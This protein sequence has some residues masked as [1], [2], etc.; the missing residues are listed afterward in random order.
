ML[1]VTNNLMKLNLENETILIIDDY[2]AMRKSIKSMLYSL[3]AKHIFEAYNGITAIATL[4]QQKIDIVL[5]DYNLGEGKNGQQILDE[6]KYE[7]LLPIS[8]L[9]II[10]TAELAA[11]SVLNTLENKP[12]DYLAKPF[13]P[14]QLLIRLEKSHSR[15][16][17]LSAIEK[18]IDQGNL[19][20]AIYYCDALLNQNNKPLRSLLLKIR[21]DLAINAGDF[22]KASS[23]YQETLEQRELPWARV[24]TGVVAFL[25]NN[26]EQAIDIFQNLI[27]QNPMLMECYDWLTKSYEA[28]GQTSAAEQTL[29]KAIE[30]VPH[31]FFRQK[32]LAI[33]AEKTD[34]LDIAEKAYLAVT[35]LGKHSIHKSPGDFTRLANIYSK[36][37]KTTEALKT[38]GSMRK[39]FDKTPEVELRAALVK[40]VVYQKTGDKKLSQH[41]FQEVITLHNKLKQKLPEEL[42]LDIAKSFYLNDQKEAAD[43]ITK[44]LVQNHIDDDNYIEDIRQMYHSIGKEGY[45]EDLIQQTKQELIDINNQGVKLYQQGKIKEAFSLFETAIEK[46]PR[47]KTIVLNM[48]KITLHNLKTSGTTKENI[49]LAHSYIKKAKEMGVPADKLGKLQLE[50]EK[51]TQKPMPETAAS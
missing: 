4:K 47:N 16:Q 44:P 7:K 13:T 43:A 14:Q 20:R 12:D 34:N 48:T 32:K 30:V 26:H 45:A 39:Q 18:E 2:S 46:M 51:I 50:F 40:T 17:F 22:N 11:S 9:F 33:L 42:Q 27:E 10:V 15:K 49:H 3:G 31:S 21:A 35:R 8:S 5:C 38:L 1:N 28:L 6:A 37:N 23:I 25:L 41:A 24:G 29:S 36:N 19:T